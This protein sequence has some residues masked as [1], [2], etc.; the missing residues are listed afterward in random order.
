MFDFVQGCLWAACGRFPLFISL[1]IMHGV[2]PLSNRK[3]AFRQAQVS[4]VGIAVVGQQETFVVKKKPPV[5]DG[6][7]LTF[8]MCYLC[9]LVKRYLREF[10]Q[11]YIV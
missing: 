8:A 4:I 10:Q 11:R 1:K 2:W 5:I 9:L 3:A 6:S 7:L